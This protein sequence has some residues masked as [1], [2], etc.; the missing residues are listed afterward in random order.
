MKCHRCGGYGHLSRDCAT[1]AETFGGGKGK[2]GKA[3]TEREAARRAETE[4]RTA[5]EDQSAAERVEK[6]REEKGTRAR[7]GSAE[8]WGTNS[9]NVPKAR[10]EE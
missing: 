8:K 5:V 1:P 7:V 6:G 3:A 9:G 2:G 10:S 4:A